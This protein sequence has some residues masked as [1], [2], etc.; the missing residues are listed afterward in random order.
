MLHRVATARGTPTSSSTSGTTSASSTATASRDVEQR[1]RGVQDGDALQAGRACRSAR[2][3]PSSTSRPTSSTRRSA[4]TRRSS[5]KDPLRVDPYR[6]LYK[7]YLEEARLRPRVVHVRGA[8]VPAQG[9]RGGAALLRGLPPAGD[10]PGEEP[11][12]QRA[13]GEEPLPRGREHLHRQDLRDDRARGASSRRSQAL[14]KAKQLPVLDRRFKQDPATST[15]TFAKTFGWAAQ[16]L[17]IQLPELYVRNDVPGALVAVPS[18]AAGVGRGSDA[19]SPASR[20]RS[21]RSS[22]AS[23]SAYYRG[24]HYIKN[25]FPTLAEL[26][27]VCFSRASR[28]SSR[29]SPSRRRWRRP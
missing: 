24:E 28:S 9:R 27:V 18:T 14:A 8:R 10:D 25:L 26:K 23:T 19:C 5:Q 1:H 6:A 20:R 2:S 12:R 21:S 3:S 11:A 13:V 29:T 17:G 16:V 7:L 4:S 22:S 15:V